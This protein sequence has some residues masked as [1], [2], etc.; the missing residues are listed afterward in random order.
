MEHPRGSRHG[1]FGVL[2]ILA[3]LGILSLA[4]RAGVFSACEYC[5]GGVIKGLRP[6]PGPVEFVDRISCGDCS[7]SGRFDAMVEAFLDCLPIIVA[8]VWISTWVGLMVLP[9][10]A[11]RVVDCPCRASQDC[12]VCRGR[13]WVTRIDRWLAKP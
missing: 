6:V 11:T 3:L 13:G 7:L 5:S 8:I 2:G 1:V 4:H 12:S 10:W 9:V